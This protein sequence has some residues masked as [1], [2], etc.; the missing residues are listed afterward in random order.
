MQDVRQRTREWVDA[1]V[2]ENVWAGVGCSVLTFV[3]GYA[4]RGYDESLLIV[5]VLFGSGFFGVLC[6][7]RFTA[8]ERGIV[9]NSVLQHRAETMIVKLESENERLVSENRRLSNQNRTHEFKQASQNA[10]VVTAQ[11]DART[12]LRRDV[13]KIIDLWSKGHKHGR[14]HCGIS[15]KRW[16]DAT[17]FL[18]HCD[19]ME[20][21]NDSTGQRQFADGLT[22]AQAERRIREA[23]AKIDKYE[24]TNFTPALS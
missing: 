14:D 23:Y 12:Q 7:V 18:V 8:D 24:S 21:A 6:M 19:V 16:G 20:I 13:A 2:I 11:D 1:T 5:A 4:W 10:K 15:R 3:C 22:V 9:W 17:Q